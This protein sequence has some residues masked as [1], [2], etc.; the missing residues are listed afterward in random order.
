MQCGRCSGFATTAGYAT[1]GASMV[2]IAA[3]ESDQPWGEQA[4]Q[5]LTELVL[6]Q[7]VEAWAVGEDR[8]GQKLSRV[9]VGEDKQTDV[10]LS[11]VAQ[12]LAWHDN[13]YSDDEDLADAEAA[14]RR[15]RKGLWAES[16]PVVPWEWRKTK[17]EH[18]ARLK[19]E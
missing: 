8:D 1:I 12:G 16:A 3:P 14:A 7:K 4:K 6:E 18:R 13:R 15:D 9:Y 2:G 11:L 5:A 10:N 19:A 17:A